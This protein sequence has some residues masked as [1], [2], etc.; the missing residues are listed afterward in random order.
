MH[1]TEEEFR[2]NLLDQL[3]VREPF[4]ERAMEMFRGYGAVHRLKVSRAIHYAAEQKKLS[5]VLTMLEEHFQNV[6]RAQ[7][8]RQ[9]GLLIDAQLRHNKTDIFFEDLWKNVLMVKADKF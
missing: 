9:R 3:K 2:V 8:P 5:P 1:I 6:V 7:P 4:R